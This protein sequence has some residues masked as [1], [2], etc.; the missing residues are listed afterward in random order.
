[1]MKAF[2]TRNHDYAQCWLTMFLMM[3]QG[4]G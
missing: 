3:K 1:M 2:T 4:V